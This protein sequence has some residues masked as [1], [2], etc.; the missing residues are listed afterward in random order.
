M[1]SPPAAVGPR[2]SSSP[3]VC[4]FALR[5]FAECQ[6]VARGVSASLGPLQRHHA[7]ATAVLA[8]AARCVAAAGARAEVLSAHGKSRDALPLFS[9]V[10]R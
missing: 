3:F 2:S 1:R 5:I 10:T 6:G 8:A 7:A 9:V 4:A